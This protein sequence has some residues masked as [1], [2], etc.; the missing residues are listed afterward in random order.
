MK[1]AFIFLIILSLLISCGKDTTA[2]KIKGSDT[3]VN[4][5]VSLAERFHQQH[6]N[7]HV[8]ISGG[9]SG[10]GI[11]SLLN[12]NADIANSSRPINPI[13][14]NLFN[15]KK[16]EIDTFI[17]A[18][19]AIA[20]I[21]ADKFS[22]DSITVAQLAAILSGKEKDWKFITGKSMPINIYGRQNNS[23]T[24][25]YVKNRLQIEYSPYAKEMN[26]NA[27]II[28]AIKADGSGI[29]YVGAG[30][31]LKGNQHGLIKVLKVKASANEPAIS[32]LDE[33]AIAAK[34]YF[35]QRPLYQYILKKSLDKAKF[36]LEFEQSQ[37]G[38]FIIKEAG[39]YPIRASLN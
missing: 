28:E 9:G 1:A 39:Y 19:D 21:V 16:I 37:Q 17:F 8:S 24:H 15:Q 32:P 35:F 13:E 11:A 20:F 26:G 27:Q 36:F 10:L 33:E 7:F 6:P 29:G 4:L 23:G 14:D 38:A 18:E 2:I 30:Y 22:I 5:V 25:D 3:E 12:G 31:V 34:R